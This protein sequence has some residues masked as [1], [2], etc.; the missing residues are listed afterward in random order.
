MKAELNVVKF[1]VEDVV[2]TSTEPSCT[3]PGVPVEE[4]LE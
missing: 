2:T 3:L 1:N 4:E